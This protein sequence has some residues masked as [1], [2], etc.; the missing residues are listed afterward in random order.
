M[1]ITEEQKEHVT[2]L[3]EAGDKLGA[4]RYMQE[5]FGLTAD[6]ALQMAEKL[7]EQLDDIAKEKMVADVH[8]TLN[9]GINPARIVGTIFGLLGLGFLATV[10]I[11]IYLDQQFQKTAIPTK[12][13]VVDMSSY[14]SRDKDT[15][16]TTT[17]Y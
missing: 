3:L 1:D 16:Q 4:V 7:D 12:G 13:K 2:S 5:E 6:Q 10:G 11:L 9:S 8:R 15:G 14:E 17:M